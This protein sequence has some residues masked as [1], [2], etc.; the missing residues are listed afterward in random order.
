MRYY[1][2][3]TGVLVAAAAVEVAAVAVWMKPPHEVHDD[4][5]V[6]ELLHDPHDWTPP[7]PPPP[8]VRTVCIRQT[9]ASFEIRRHRTHE[10][11]RDCQMPRRDSRQQRGTDADHAYC[12]ECVDA[13]SRYYEALLY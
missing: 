1:L 7:P 8:H 9:R 13:R 6:V 10:V 2:S 12:D 4:S 3:S 11:M 5:G